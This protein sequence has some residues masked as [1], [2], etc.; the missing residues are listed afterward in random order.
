[1]E[2]EAQCPVQSMP[3]WA[4]LKRDDPGSMPVTFSQLWWY[5][6]ALGRVFKW[7]TQTHTANDFFLDAVIHGRVSVNCEQRLI[8][9]HNKRR[10]YTG[11]SSDTA[12][13]RFPVQIRPR[14]PREC[15]L[16]VSPPR[17]TFSDQDA[18]IDAICGLR[19]WEHLLERT[20]KS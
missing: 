7:K 8:S 12:R 1:M 20:Q 19:L 14:C 9:S 5:W 11:C 18:R 13:F 15:F 10:S 2:S 3:W 16:S 4:I 6:F 17:G